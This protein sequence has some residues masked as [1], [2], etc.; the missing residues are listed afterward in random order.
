MS[1][2]SGSAQNIL[3]LVEQAQLK[4]L[5]GEESPG[6]GACFAILIK[7][8]NEDSFKGSSGYD[9]RIQQL[10]KTIYN[11]AKK[12]VKQG[13]GHLGLTFISPYLNRL[14]QFVYQKTFE[15]QFNKFTGVLWDIKQGIEKLPD[16]V[17]SI[18]NNA[19]LKD[20]R[21]LGITGTANKLSTSQFEPKQ[22]IEETKHSLF[23]MGL[24][25]SKWVEDKEKFIDFLKRV[26]S[27]PNGRVRY[28]MIDPNGDSF[29]LLKTMRGESLKD[30]STEVFR[31]LVEEFEC[32]EARFYEFLPCFRLIFIDNKILAASRYKLDESNY[33]KSKKGWEAPHLVIDAEQGDWSLYEPFLSYYETIWKQSKDIKEVLP[34][35]AK[36][37]DKSKNRRNPR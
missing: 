1:K 18:D 11:T 17:P 31:E 12:L 4:V 20:L 30:K 23:F 8:L 25:G 19:Y 16:S 27:K 14:S 34:K 29:K 28:L 15:Q 7:K 26:Q 35:K 24:L 33:I 32:L 10:Q 6:T 37:D 13:K 9:L 2:V 36:S 21:A 5:D 3:S 22:C